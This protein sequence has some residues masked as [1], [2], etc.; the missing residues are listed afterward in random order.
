[1][2]N[3]KHFTFATHWQPSDK[4]IILLF[5]SKYLT[6]SDC[7]KTMRLSREYFYIKPKSHKKTCTVPT[8]YLSYEHQQQTTIHTLIQLQMTTRCSQWWQTSPLLPPPHGHD[9]IMLS[10][11]QLVP[12]HL[13]NWTKHMHL[14]WFWPTPS[15]IWKHDTIYKTGST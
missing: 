6:I 14:L 3:K 9:Q 11:I 4:A 8:V 5:Q 15:I 1:M 12:R 2:Q 13:V 7:I 10:D